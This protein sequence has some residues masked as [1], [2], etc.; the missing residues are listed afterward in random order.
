MK[1][2]WHAALCGGLGLSAVAI[3]MVAPHPARAGDSSPEVLAQCALDVCRIIVN[4]SETG[5]DIACDLSKTWAKEEIAEK[6]AGKPIS[7]VLGNV[8]CAVKVDF[9]RASI[10][11][12][13][14]K[15]EYTLKARPHA[16]KCEI[17]KDSSMDR[18]SLT[19]EPVVTFKD[20]QAVKVSLGASNLNAPITISGVLWT[21]VQLEKLGVFEKDM[22]R[23]V[24]KFVTKKCPEMV[25]AA[26]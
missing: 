15:K 10:V 22:V 18:V 19:L 16:V 9:E 3:A 14:K 4:R 25:H 26:K 20:G 6:S 11:S 24:N 21:A 8:H 23:E 12:A 7:W 13:L 1:S 5:K 17:G 2:Y